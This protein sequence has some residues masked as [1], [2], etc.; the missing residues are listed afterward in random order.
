MISKTKIFKRVK[1]KNSSEIVETLTACRKN[2]SWMKVGKKIS[3]SRK[4]YDSINL[5][6]IDSE[7]KEGDTVVVVGRV[8]GSGDISK[9]VRICALGFSKTAEEKLSA[10]KGEL[11]SVLEEIKKNPKAEGVRL[12]Q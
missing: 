8:L 11:V 5:K 10:V 2:N 6:R 12:L 4:G 9:K 7:T 3:G 1:R